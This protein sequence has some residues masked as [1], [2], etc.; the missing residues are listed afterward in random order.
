MHL[1]SVATALLPLLFCKERFQISGT[2]LK[3]VTAG[4]GKEQKQSK[5]LF[6]YLKASPREQGCSNSLLLETACHMSVNHTPLHTTQ[7]HHMW[8]QPH[9][10]LPGCGL[11]CCTTPSTPGCQL[12]QHCQLYH[13][14]LLHPGVGAG[15]WKL[16]KGERRL[17]TLAAASATAVGGGRGGSSGWVGGQRQQKNPLGT[18]CSPQAISW[19]V[20]L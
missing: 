16:E 8:P 20:L 2:V 14:T 18:A 4:G 3:F 12:P 9:S 11:L 7:M 17:K 13:T 19:T 6:K 10:Q 5:H 15:K 1:L